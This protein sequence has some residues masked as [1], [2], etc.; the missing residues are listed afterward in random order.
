MKVHGRTREAILKT[1]QIC[2]DRN[3]LKKYLE[4]KEKEVVAI[5]LAMLDEKEILRDYIESKKYEAAQEAKRENAKETVTQLLKM[6]RLSVEEI[7]QCVLA[8]KNMKRN[9]A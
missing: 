2:K 9:K 6:G 5:M 7:V 8:F 3:V 4:E 1:I